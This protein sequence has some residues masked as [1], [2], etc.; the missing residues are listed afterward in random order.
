LSHR[1]LVTGYGGFL[2]LAICHQLI[3]NGYRVRGLARGNYPQLSGMGVECIQGSITDP[4]AVE[5]SLRDIDAVIHTAAIAGVWGKTADYQ[6]INIDATDLILKRSQDAGIRAFTPAP[7]PS[8][9][10]GCLLP[11][12]RQA[13]R[14]VRSGRI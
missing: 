9:N 5:T 7:K 12:I 14:L 11:T 4:L 6:S 1:I 3:Q 10:N 2:G 8:Q 13:L